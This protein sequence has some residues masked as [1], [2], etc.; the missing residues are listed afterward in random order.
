RFASRRI[1]QIGSAR[2]KAEVEGAL[3]QPIKITLA[4]GKG[5]RGESLALLSDWW[6]GQPVWSGSVH[7][8]PVS[9]QVRPVRNGYALAARGMRVEAY[10]YT[11]REAALAALMPQRAPPNTAKLLL[12]PMPGQL[13][14]LHVAVGQEIKAGEALCVVEAMKMEN[15]LRADRDGVVKA[16]KASPGD[17]LAVDAVIMEFA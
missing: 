7:G 4:A 15:V 5:R 9:V 12:C 14:A 17:S 13:K 3:N 10:V 11:E 1:A 8:R 6:P 16:L 2:V